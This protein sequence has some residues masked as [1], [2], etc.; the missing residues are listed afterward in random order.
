MPIVPGLRSPYD[1]VGR[2]VYLGR[3]LDKIR[4]HA[5]GK[6]PADYHA[7]LGDT[8]PGMFDTRCCSF[9]GVSYDEIKRRTLAGATDEAVLQ[10]AEETGGRR[11]DEDCLVW[12]SFLMKRGW[13]DPADNVAQ[14]A[15]RVKEGGLEGKGIQT[16]FDYI[17]CDEG[18]DPFTPKRWET[19]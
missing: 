7:N 17:D 5:A 15:K 18:R 10:W 6:L 19:V 2:V 12:N 8:Q 3:L 9:L 4:L 14:L 16:F 13:H 11:S 1:K